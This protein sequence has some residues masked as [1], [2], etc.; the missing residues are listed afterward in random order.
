MSTQVK[1]FV[2]KYSV[3]KTYQPKQ[4]LE[5]LLPYKLPNRPWT[6]VG[7]D[8]FTFEDTNYLLI[9]DYFS[10]YFEVH[11]LTTATSTAV[12]QKLRTQYSR[13]G[14]P[15]FACAEFRKLSNDW[16]FEHTTSS[17]RYPQSS[18][19]VDNAV[20]GNMQDAD[21]ESRAVKDGHLSCFVCVS[22]YTQ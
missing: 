1:E 19:K 4:C 15:Q 9:A 11:Y 3:R 2:S 12:I 22:E 13:H 16:E 17:P 10:N 21:E 6:V 20:T 7:I 14:I 8:L 18:G 5:P